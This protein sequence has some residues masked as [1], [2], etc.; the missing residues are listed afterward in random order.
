MAQSNI[1]IGLTV[2]DLRVRLHILTA[3]LIVFGLTAL[4]SIS[5]NPLSIESSFM[6]QFIFMIFSFIIY[7]FVRRVSLKAIHD[8][9]TMIFLFTIGLCLV[10]FFLPKVEYTYRWI[11][12]N[13]MT[14][15]PS[16]YL[17]IGL[18]IVIAKY[19]SDNQIRIKTKSIIIIP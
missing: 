13:F 8:N 2:E 10:P 11:D 12:L 17:K 1:Y 4:Y 15:Q 7:L 16:E 9:S 14:I 3:F 6:R 5:D 18:I 19:L